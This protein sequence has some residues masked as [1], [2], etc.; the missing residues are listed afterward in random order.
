[1]AN[2]ATEQVQALQQRFADL[3]KQYEMLS[4]Y[5]ASMQAAFENERRRAARNGAIAR[6]GHLISSSL[7]LNEIFQTAVEAI[8]EHLDFAYIA[9]GLIDPEDPE[10]LRL[11]AQ[12]GVFV[13]HIPSDYRHSIHVGIVGE[14]ARTRRQVLVDNVAH[15]ERYIA[16]VGPTIRA[17]LATPIRMGERLLGVLNIEAEHPISAEDA[18]GI[19]VIADQLAVALDHAH[20]FER[21]Q[22]ALEETQLIANT[23]QRISTA[24]T[25]DDVVRAYL[26]QVAQRRRFACT[27]V[28]YE[29]DTTGA[30]V[31]VR[32]RG[33]WSAQRGLQL[34]DTRIT[35]TRDQLD[36]LLD[37]GQ[38]VV[39][40]NVHTDPRVTETLREMQRRDARP[41]LAMI[42]LMVRG[43]RIGLVVLSYGDVYAWPDLELQ[44]YQATAAQLAT[45]IDSRRQQQLLMEQG[46]Q[47]AVLDERRRLARELHDSVTQ[48]LFS[49]S[50]LAQVV[51]DLWELDPGEARAMLGQI[52]DLTRSAL[53]EMRALLFELRPAALGKQELAQALRQHATVFE[54]RTGI[55]VT[56]DVHGDWVLP[57]AVEQALF[58]IAQEALAN[59]A[60]HAHAAQVQLS[61]QGG[62]PL[63]LRVADDGHGFDPARVGD[64]HLGLVSMR[65]RVEAIGAQMRIHSSASGGTEVVVEW[66]RAASEPR[67]EK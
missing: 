19:A 9:A 7:S 8:Y 48:S 45:A 40:P 50:L 24:M 66:S 44:P 61:L 65:E 28:L 60:R 22:R 12:T 10:Y 63:R 38:T 31:A 2:I 30:R 67:G 16:M 26:E 29:F 64:G 36:P 42:P 27:V 13:R 5:V 35:Y 20:L 1:M 57:T 37:A 6:I 14:A 39:I 46:Q 15:D 23:S 62:D 51:P 52:R 53:A 17:E 54:Q 34:M 33:F 18:E 49:M 55:R 59:V 4:R 58:R 11:I 21:T 32:I 47:V 25:V 3:T 41:A 43:A 56:V